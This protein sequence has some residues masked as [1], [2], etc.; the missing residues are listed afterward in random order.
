M[1]NQP[2]QALYDELADCISLEGEAKARAKPIRE[3]IERRLL[4]DGLKQDEHNGWI[5]TLKAE[6]LSTAWLKRQGWDE[7]NIPAD[8]ISEKVVP[9]INWPLVKERLELPTT[10]TLA[11]SRKKV[12]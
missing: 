1:N 12:K 2:I 5:F 4:A 8:C 11:V 6:A 10:F 3:E 9:D 7:T